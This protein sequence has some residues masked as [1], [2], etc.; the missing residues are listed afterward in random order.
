MNHAIF[1]FN[2]FVVEIIHPL[3][4]NGFR[5]IVS[6]IRKY[7]HYSG[8]QKDPP[9][10]TMQTI[11]E[12][13]LNEII[14]ICKDRK[15][16]RLAAFGSVACDRFDP[17]RSDLDLLVKFEAISP[18]DHAEQY[19]GLAEDLEKLFSRPKDLVEP[20]PIRNPYFRKSLEETQVELYA[21]A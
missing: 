16:R 3:R 18:A 19:F 7:E 8:T 11:I 4:T 14:R 1:L 15:V 10:V 5:S 9:A 17:T 12:Q 21:A 6:T 2:G 13:N 20:G